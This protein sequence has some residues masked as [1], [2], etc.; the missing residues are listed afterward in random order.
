MKIETNTVQS[1]DRA[2]YILELLSTH[3]DGLA[4]TEISKS[5]DL[6]KSTVHRLLLTLIHHGYVSQNAQTQHYHLSLKMFEIGSRMIENIDLPKVARPYLELLSQLTNE[7]VHVVI[8]DGSDIVYIDKVESDNNIRMHSRIGAKS[9]MYSTSAGKAM[10]AFLPES[11]VK[12]VWDKSNIEKKTPNTITVYEELLERL[13]KVKM[14]GYALDE[15]E[16]EDGIQCVGAPIFDYKNNIV[17]A[18]SISGP[19]M[20]VTYD[21]ID[22]FKDQLLTYSHQISKELGWKGNVL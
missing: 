14:D 6:H 16:N 10:L 15:E 9:P 3:T 5:I 22:K 1:I 19:A 12:E 11:K 4:L 8:P 2:I 13:K 21:F 20:R 7:V 17:G 18:I